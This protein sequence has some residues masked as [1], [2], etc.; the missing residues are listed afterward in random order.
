[1]IGEGKIL[2]VLTALGLLSAN[3]TLADEPHP[4]LKSAEALYRQDGPELA[5]P[6]FA[7]LATRFKTEQDEYNEAMAVHFV[8]V[9][10]WRLGNFDESRVH[11]DEALAMRNMLDDKLGVA[12]TAMVLGLLEWDLGNYDQAIARFRTASEAGKEIGD[13][14]VEGAALNNLSLVY[15]ELGDYKTSLA[16][17]ETVL[18]IYDGADFPRGEGDTYGNIGGVYLLLGQYRMALSYYEKALAISIDL[19][20]KLSIGQDHGNIGLAHLG[21]GDIDTAIGHFDMAIDLAEETGMRQDAAYWQGAKAN[22][23]IQKG[24]YDAGLEI[25]RHALKSYEEIG[26]RGELLVALHDMGQLHLSLGDATSAESYFTRAISIARE[27]GNANGM[28]VNLLA[29]G[30]L[31]FRREQLDA[32]ANHFN[33]ARQRAS[34]SEAQALLIESLIGLA[35]VHQDQRRFDE[36]ADELGTALEISRTIESRLQEAETLFV[37]AENNRRN[38]NTEGALPLYSAAESI[39][40]NTGDP[41]ILWQLHFGRAKTLESLGD[42]KG[43]I[44]SLRRSVLLIE[45]VRGRLREERFRSGYLQDKYQVYVELVRLQLELDMTEEAFQTAERLRAR[46]YSQQFERVGYPLLT[47]DQQQREHELRERIRQLQRALG[48]EQESPEIRQAAVQTF[49]T[50]LIVAEREYQMFLDDHV[51]TV[52]VQ[53][54][55][56][57]ISVSA[58]VRKQLSERDLLIEYVVGESEVMIFALSS[59]G[60]IARIETIRQEDMQARVELLRDLISRPGDSRWLK[61]AASIADVLISPLV[62]AGVLEGISNLYLVPHGILNYL[63]FSTLPANVIGDQKLLLED[64]TI[65]YLPTAVAI[66]AVSKSDSGGMS[67]LALAPGNSRLRYAPGEARLIDALFQPNS[68]LLLGDAATES[69]FKTL[70][71]DY[72]MLHLATH[73]DFNKLNP[74]FSSLQLEADDANDGRLEVHEVLRLK[75]NADL[76]TLSACDTAL[77]SGYFAEVPAGDEFVGLTRAFLSVG[78]D[79]VM[80]TLWEVDDRSSVQLMQQFYERL[81]SLGANADKSAALMLAQQQL[82]STKGYEHPYYWAPFVLVEKMSNASVTRTQVPETRL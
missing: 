19:E 42:K 81:E 29:L 26:A 77:G 60:M 4:D 27:I 36:A 14:K 68:R 31:Y 38:E 17:Y 72:R 55:A 8:G 20:S 56:A 79:S 63:P 64:F 9:C 10:H 32:A 43:A 52:A 45:S 58:D 21:L 73:S 41:N 78:S 6:Q 75:L 34:Q 80:A 47:E 49:S 76:V 16:Q 30:K 7:A 54:P 51:Q 40:T 48:E 24:R 33:Q 44:E 69:R 2:I 5:L 23:L 28:T 65:A 57:P 82:R 61:P 12:K 11:L 66:G 39:L 25:H 59:A 35:Y 1:M 37:S 74:M 53:T 46:S 22:A 50:E 70:A 71:G 67:M 18:E 62:R 13:R 15:D 3:L